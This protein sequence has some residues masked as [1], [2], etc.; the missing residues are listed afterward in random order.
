MALRIIRR[1]GNAAQ[2]AIRGALSVVL[3][4]G[5]VEKVYFPCLLCIC[6]LSGDLSNGASE[7][8]DGFLWMR[9]ADS[10]CRTAFL[11]FLREIGEDMRGLSA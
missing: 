4:D 1:R 6:V 5:N 11:C 2:R 7:G 8:F 3:P 9:D 10:L